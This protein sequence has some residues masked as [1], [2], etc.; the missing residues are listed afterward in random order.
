LIKFRQYALKYL[1]YIGRIA[2]I[3]IVRMVWENV[4]GGGDV[5]NKGGFSWKRAVGI[6]KMKNKISRATGIPLT[7]SGRQR[8]IGKAVIDVFVKKPH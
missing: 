3:D 8:K 5:M 7:K 4:G 1:E 2:Y 6:T